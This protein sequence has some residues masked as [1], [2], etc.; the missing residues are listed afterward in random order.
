MVTF[1]L[2]VFWY[3]DVFVMY[4]TPHSKAAGSKRSSL[5]TSLH[6]AC[7]LKAPGLSGCSFANLWCLRTDK[8][9]YFWG[10][11]HEGHIWADVG[12]HNL[13]SLEVFYIQTGFPSNFSSNPVTT[14]TYS[15][16]WGFS[17]C[18][19]PYLDLPCPCTLL[20][21]N[22]GNGSLKTIEC[23]LTTFSF[24]GVSQSAERSPWFLTGTRLEASWNPNPINKPWNCLPWSFL[25]MTVNKPWR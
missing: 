1:N 20:F 25:M 9:F 17:W 4:P 11:F 24:E 13:I 23:L 7:F 5:T 19:R 6:G 16:L 10:H 2:I 21:L 14:R 12:E 18:S 3:F 8:R 22:W 15:S